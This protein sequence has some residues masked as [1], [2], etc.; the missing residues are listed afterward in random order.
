MLVAS[1]PDAVAVSE[2]LERSVLHRSAAQS[3]RKTGV[4]ND[5]STADVDAMMRV[6]RARCDETRSEWGSSSGED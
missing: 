4:V 3:V 1:N 6:E 2:A 5:A